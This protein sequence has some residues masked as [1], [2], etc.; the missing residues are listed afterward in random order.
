MRVRVDYISTRP[1]NNTA[2]PSGVYLSLLDPN[3][4]EVY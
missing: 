3:G 1:V 2:G 4:Y